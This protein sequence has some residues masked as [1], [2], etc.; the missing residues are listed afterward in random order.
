MGGTDRDG[1]LVRYGKD[2]ES[3]KRATRLATG[4]IVEELELLDGRLQY[5]L[6]SGSGPAT[7][8]VSLKLKS[9]D[10]LVPVASSP[11]VSPRSE[12]EKSGTVSRLL[13]D[14]DRQIATFAMG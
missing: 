10:L 7:G 9:K 14:S 2:F 12:F 5:M 4:S 13:Q 3:P 6:V 11:A 1:I 8:W